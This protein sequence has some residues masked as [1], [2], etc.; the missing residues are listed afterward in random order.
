MTF[1]GPPPFETETPIIPPSS[2]QPTHTG[3]L[4]GTGSG[5][6]TGW[7]MVTLLIAGAG[8]IIIGWSSR[9]R[10]SGR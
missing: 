6:T 2:A 1:T 10:P 3:Q 9:G 8:G 7:A 5:S 4:P